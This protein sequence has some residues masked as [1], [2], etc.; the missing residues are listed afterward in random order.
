MNIN[1]LILL[2][3]LSCYE[4]SMRWH[5]W[6][7]HYVRV[8]S[9][10]TT[11]ITQ[12]VLQCYAAHIWSK[13]SFYFLS[14]LLPTQQIKENWNFRELS[15]WT[16]TQMVHK[17]AMSSCSQGEQVNVKDP[18]SSETN[19]CSKHRHPRTDQITGENAGQTTLAEAYQ[20][21]LNEMK[22]KGDSK[23]FVTKSYYL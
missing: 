6:D 18:M 16:S 17:W 8:M 13:K 15:G 20:Q 4:N 2:A 7:S 23:S 14:H 22:L 3:S 9:Q 10:T 12:K 11:D 19:S 5:I 1:T 21:F